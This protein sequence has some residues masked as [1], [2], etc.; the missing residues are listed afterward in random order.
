MLTATDANGNKTSYSDYHPAGYPET[1][2]DPLGHD[3][4]TA[5]D[6]RGNVLSITDAKGKKSTYTY[7]VFG[8]PLE[9]QVP[10]DQDQGEFITTPAPVYDKNDNV[11]EETASNG[12]VTTYSYDKAD[13]MASTTEPEDTADGPERKTTYEYDLVGNLLKQTEP[14]GNLTPDNPEDFVTTYG[15]DKIY[16]MTSVTNADGDKITYEY[17]NVGNVVT[18]VDPKKNKTTDTTDYTTKI[19]YNLNHQVTKE[20]DAEGHSTQYQYDLDGNKTA[21]TDKEGHTTTVTYDE[22]GLVEEVK[23]PHKDGVDRVTQYAYDEVG[24][25]T[26]VITPRGVETSTEGDY[27]H[28]T[29][30]DAL[31]RVKEKIFPYDPA[32]S[33]S[34]YNQPHKMT[35][36]YDEVGNR[37]QVSA[38]PSDGQTDPDGN[39]LRNETTYEYF[40]NGWVQSSTDPWNIQTSYGYNEL[41]LQTSRT[42]TSAGGSNSRTMGWSYYPDGKRK[43]KSDDGV[44]VGKDVVLVDNSDT[45]NVEFSGDWKTSS[46]VDGHQGYSYQYDYQDSGYPDS[47]A[48]DHFFTWKLNIPKDGDYEVWVS[49]QKYKDRATNAPY[50]VEYDGGTDT[51]E[52][53][54]NTASG[55]ETEWKKL[56][57]YAF[58]AGN[59]HQVTLTDD[60]DRIVVADAVKLVRD[61][62]GRR[63]TKPKTLPTPTMPTAT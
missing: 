1:T 32:S 42:L 20:T 2:T 19:A 51:V 49:Y 21:V 56:G 27:V 3:T 17:D 34:R 30:Y 6:A 31:N 37:V 63:T 26:H 35:Y 61:N 43:A 4:T 10:K 9:S 24:N 59:T 40:D 47:D 54:Q 55:S 22:R 13:Q 45:P 5:Y 57:T 44:P 14:K 60:A 39:A 12:A 7:D 53:N 11:T 15:Y 18:V 50:T 25:R 33:D 62:S 58:Q 16:Q 28:E 52:V 36:T 29:K 8:R 48:D 46:N 41:G 38:P 23:A